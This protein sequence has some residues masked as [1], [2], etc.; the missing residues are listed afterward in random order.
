[1]SMRP[2]VYVTRRVPERLRFELEEQFDVT[3]HDADTPPSR[4]ELLAGV[5]GQA[6]V[7]SMVSDTIDDEFLDAAGPQLRV[8]ANYAVGFDNVDVDACARHGV[9][10]TNIPDVLTKP[11][12]ELTIA[13]LLNATR[14][15]AEGDRLLRSEVPWT[16]S[17]THMLGETLRG[18]LLAV[19]GLGHIGREV[20]RIAEALGMRIVYTD[21]AGR[22]DDVSW[23]FL[24][25]DELVERADVITLHCPLTPETRH[26]INCDVLR[27]MKR[28]A[29]LVNTSRGPVIDESAL[30]E[31]L[32]TG[33]I[34]GAALDVFEREPQV[35]QRLLRCQNVVLTP[36][37]GSATREARDAMG[38]L[39][40]S[41]VKGVLLE[42]VVPE[43]ALNG[44]V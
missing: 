41:A 14:R 38:K 27:A 37:L 25:F 23:E 15:V 43:N 5:S 33:E 40:L 4:G 19:V 20:A 28:T 11:T 3:L 34:A 44:R 21:A 35:E 31:A 13:L 1:M 30:A 29:Y 22:Q 9:I 2:K 16:W 18:R 10:A 7:V 8:V 6:G 39:C 24:A 12:A 36:H 26:L 42:G 17:P 32:E